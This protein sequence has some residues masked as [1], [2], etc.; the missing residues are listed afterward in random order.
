MTSAKDML[1]KANHILEGEDSILRTKEKVYDHKVQY[2]AIEGYPMEAIPY[3]KQSNISDLVYRII[4]PIIFDFILKTGRGSI[5][6]L[7]EKEIVSIETA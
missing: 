1:I 3:F 5:Q 6:L 4:G 2:L 7:R